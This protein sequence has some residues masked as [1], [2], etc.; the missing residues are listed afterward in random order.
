MI[1]VVRGR[2]SGS[3]RQKVSEAILYWWIAIY[4]AYH[5]EFPAVL[6]LIERRIRRG[7]QMQ[8]YEIGM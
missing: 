8:L 6:P 4:V 3:V 2:S 7:R 5:F 1:A